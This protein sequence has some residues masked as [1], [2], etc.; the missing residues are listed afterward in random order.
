MPQFRVL[1]LL[2]YTI[3]VLQ[4]ATSENTAGKLAPIVLRRAAPSNS[5]LEQNILCLL[6]SL[7]LHPEFFVGF[8]VIVVVVVYFFLFF[9]S[10]LFLVLFSWVMLVPP[11]K[12][13]SDIIDTTAAEAESTRK[14][15]ITFSL[16]RSLSIQY[17]FSTSCCGELLMLICCY[18][19]RIVCWQG[20]Y[21]HAV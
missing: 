4:W 14:H 13:C 11:L 10:F 21:Q 6:P 12:S 7:F 20:H 8:F 1:C 15:H 2:R 9:F 5:A 17:D 16:H 18:Y 19:L 3:T